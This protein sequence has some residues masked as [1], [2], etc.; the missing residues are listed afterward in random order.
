MDGKPKKL[1][2]VVDDEVTTLRALK[3]TLE[4]E[5]EVAIA[6]SAENAFAYLKA[7]TPDLILLDYMMPVTDGRETLLQLRSDP[8]T[9][10]IPVIFLT[11]MSDADTVK[12]CMSMDAQGYL[13]K[14]INAHIL[15]E[16]V[17]RF[18]SN[19]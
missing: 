6:G 11:A 4:A 1:I 9:K 18:F 13:L 8:K 16:R 3:R 12:E 2:L 7:H 10:D 17:A 5:Y 19:N 15:L 14:P